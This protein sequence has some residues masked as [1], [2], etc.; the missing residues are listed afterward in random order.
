LIMLILVFKGLMIGLLIA[1]P[2][3]QPRL[4]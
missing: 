4:Q 1:V 3:R 2:F